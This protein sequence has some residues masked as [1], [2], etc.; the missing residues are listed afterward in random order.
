VLFVED[1]INPESILF[2]G[3]LGEKGPDHTVLE[4]CGAQ[5]VPPTDWYHSS[6]EENGLC[7]TGF[8]YEC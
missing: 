2:C 1:I 3:G 7:G 4:Q 5:V 8:A 6:K